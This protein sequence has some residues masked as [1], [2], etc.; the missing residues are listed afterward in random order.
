MNDAAVYHLLRNTFFQVS[1]NN[2]WGDKSSTSVWKSQLHWYFSWGQEHAFEETLLSSPHYFILLFPAGQSQSTQAVFIWD[3]TK[4][5]CP[6]CAP[7][8]MGTHSA[9][10][11]C[12]FKRVSVWMLGLLHSLLTSAGSSP[13][14][15]HNCAPYIHHSC[16]HVPPSQEDRKT[17]FWDRNYFCNWSEHLNKWVFA[18]LPIQTPLYNFTGTRNVRVTKGIQT[19]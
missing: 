2:P 16:Q 18:K 9:G 4:L 19:D 8:L 6:E 7:L 3:E 13:L 5:G 11:K 17:K 15:I 10:W 1:E 12:T 14:R